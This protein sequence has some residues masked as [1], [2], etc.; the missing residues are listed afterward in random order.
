MS[1]NLVRVFN[2]FVSSPG[3][4]QAERDVLDHVVAGINDTDGRRDNFRLE[5]FRWERKTVPQIGPGPQ[6]AVDAWTPSYD[7]YL[8]IMSTRF[9]TPTERAGSGTEDEFN[10]ALAQ[11][12]MAGAPWI[13]FY[14]DV[15]PKAINDIAQHEQQGKVLAFRLRLEKLGLVAKYK[16]VEGGNKAFRT[17]VDLH[18]RK[19][20]GR[21]VEL[22]RTPPAQATTT[23]SSSPSQ[24]VIPA[25]GHPIFINGSQ[26]TVII[27]G[28]ADEAQAKPP[29]ADPTRYL[30]LL[31]ERNAN[32]EIR[33]LQVASGRAPLFPIDE[34]YIPLKTTAVRGSLCEPSKTGETGTL[35]DT[36]VNEP[37]HREL[38][39]NHVEL[40]EALVETRLV[41]IGDPGA[42][43]TTLLRRVAFLLSAAILKQQTAEIRKQLGWAEPLF[44]LWMRVSDVAQFIA[45]KTV[46]TSL[47]EFLAHACAADNV[48]LKKEFFEQQLDGGQALVML[49]GLDEAPNEQLRKQVADLFERTTQRYP[50]C[51]YLV[52]SRPAAMLRE[53]VLPGYSQVEIELLEDDAIETF[54]KRWCHA[55]FATS[56]TLAEKQLAELLDALRQRIEIRR[57]AR[58]PVMLTALAVVHWNEK[59]LPEQRADLYESI[60]LWLARARAQRPGRP[61]PERCVVLL[62]DLALAMQNHPEGRQTQ[63]TQHWAASQLA[64]LW[65]E[66]PEAERVAAATKFLEDEEGDSGII[67]KRGD[68]VRYW[69]LTFQEFLAARALTAHDKVRIQILSQPKLYEPEWKEVALLLAGALYHQ[70]PE[71]VDAMF[72][73]ILDQLGSRASLVEKAL[74]VG[75]LGEAVHDLSVVKF[76]PRD[77]RYAK[78]VRELEAVFEPKWLGQAETM[79]TLESA[80]TSWTS[81]VRWA[82]WRPSL[83]DLLRLAIRVADVLGHVGTL[84]HDPAQLD[85]LWIT[86]PAGSFWMGSQSSSPEGKNFDAAS[87]SS[88]EPVHEVELLDFQIAKFPITVG[89]YERFVN[90]GGYGRQQFWTAG[91]YGQFEAPKLWEGQLA[92]PNRPVVNVSWFEAR[93]YCAWRGVELPTE[94]QWERAARGTTSR[95]Y[96]WGDSPSPTC[97]RANFAGCQS[98]HPTP[99]GIFPLGATPDGIEELAGNVFEWCEDIYEAYPSVSARD[100]SARHNGL[101]RVIRGGSSDSTA[102]YCRSAIRE[103]SSPECRGQRIGFR[104]ALKLRLEEQ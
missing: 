58:N 77:P 10:A 69:H 13:M 104:V 4:V 30:K 95:R 103:F 94:A 55:L 8:G 79:D 97:A 91:G 27:Q 29:P 90:F 78:L 11:W 100:P 24:A 72:S 74:C 68:H 5:L 41:I 73:S 57:M 102:K 7:I 63:V 6:P 3:D 62:Q 32:I 70:G 12:Q 101:S 40:S 25:C 93:A 88:E 16:K 98:P 42:G 28:R 86:I 60:I 22:A 2:V 47:P 81:L 43:K 23:S 65:R 96:P 9:G 1:N 99:V 33:G 66:L 76:Q 83:C 34:L 37:G 89:Q 44:P 14:F 36:P 45:G 59:R 19:V 52:S 51:R 35:D 31:R 17:Q 38:R 15:V 71:R 61:P 56:P 54:L 53:P 49:D 67:V 26:T 75:L 39:S 85:N 82:H 20:A 92:H 50:A 48:G 18:L 84:R 46:P 87:R 80:R 64:P 21:L